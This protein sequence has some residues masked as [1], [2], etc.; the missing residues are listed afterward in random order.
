MFNDMNDFVHFRLNNIAGKGFVLLAIHSECLLMIFFLPKLKAKKI[1]L[2]PASIRQKKIRVYVG[3]KNI[4]FFFFYYLFNFH[5]IQEQ[6][7]L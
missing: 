4:L 3:Q 1:V 5:E 6:G 7:K 2:F